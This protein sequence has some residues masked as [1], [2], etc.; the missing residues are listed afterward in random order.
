MERIWGGGPG[1]FP[2]G[3]KADDFLRLF[4]DF[5][6]GIAVYREGDVAGI[7]AGVITGLD[8]ETIARLSQG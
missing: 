1:F 8:E 3:R 5:E 2:A 7:P 6:F 4:S